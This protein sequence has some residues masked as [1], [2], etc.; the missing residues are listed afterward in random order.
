MGASTATATADE[1][2]GDGDGDG[3]NNFSTTFSGVP[4]SRDFMQCIGGCEQNG[5]ASP[6]LQ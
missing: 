2:D 1:F 6:S 5:Y 4:F 3:D